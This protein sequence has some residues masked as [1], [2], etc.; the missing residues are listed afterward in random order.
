MEGDP[1]LGT[2]MTDSALT[3]V[4]VILDRSGSMETIRHDMV[5]GFRRLIREQRAQPGR[6]VLSLYQFD[7]VYEKCFEERDIDNVGDLV[8]EPRGGTALLDAVARAINDVGYRLQNK[9]EPKRPGGVIVLIITDGH[10][11]ASKFHSREQV[12]QMIAH[13]ETK[14]AW[15]FL[16]LS[17]DPAAFAAAH[18][19]G[20][21]LQQAAFFSHNAAGT[22]AMYGGISASI[23][24][25]R[26]AVHE[27]AVANWNAGLGGHFGDAEGIAGAPLVQ[28]PAPVTIE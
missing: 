6:C 28:P 27:G 9:P 5:G 14:Y 22:G 18:D 25:Y 16:Y 24:S 26:H 11:N 20:I 4:V 23:G 1:I 2:T 19:L 13:Q 17:A 21:P 7:T 12:R 3:E 10:E 15:K 8:L